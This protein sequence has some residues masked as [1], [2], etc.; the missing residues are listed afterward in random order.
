M[1]TEDALLAGIV[2]HPGELERWLILADWLEDHGDPRAEL[3]RLRFLLHTEPDHPE[4]LRRLARQLELLETGLAP[5]VPTRTNGLGIE[6]ALILPGTFLM[7]SPETEPARRD[8]E[9]LHSVTLTQPFFLGVYPVTVGAFKR[10]VATTKYQTEAEKQGGAWVLVSGQWKPDA[11]ITW[12][13]PGYEQTDQHPVV[14]VSWND[15]QAMV[16]W[17]NEAEADSGVVYSLPTEAQWEYACRAG[18]RT[19]FWFG[20]DPEKLADHAWF[21]SNSDNRTHPVNT[22]KPNAWGLWHMHGLVWEWCADWYDAY[23]F[24]AV[25]DPLGSSGG[26]YRVIRGGSW[27]SGPAGC[28][29]ASRDF[30]DPASRPTRSG[31][32]LAA[33]VRAS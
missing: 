5:V 29:S 28:C 25:Q 12:R 6:L 13:S 14:C 26:S 19:A 17:L 7:G 30:G 27:P 32:R 8:D 11:S 31:F 2:A 10:F 15:A 22:G 3:A 16:A 33:S 24:T 23:P 20:D 9:T 1:S 21:R 4:L 18:T